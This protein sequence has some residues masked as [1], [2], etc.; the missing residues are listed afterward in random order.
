MYV[1]GARKHVH[2]LEAF[3]FGSQSIYYTTNGNKMQWFTPVNNLTGRYDLYF[4]YQHI[5]EGF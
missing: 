4:R 1:L 2:R 3:L 5:N